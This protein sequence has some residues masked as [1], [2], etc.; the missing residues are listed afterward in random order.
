MERRPARPSAFDTLCT[1]RPGA[2]LLRQC[3]GGARGKLRGLGRAWA[4]GRLNND[5]AAEDELAAEARAFGIDPQTLPDQSTAVWPDAAPALDAFLAVA[6][7]W[8]VTPSGRVIGLDYAAVRAGL[9]LAG[10]EL[11][12]EVWSDVQ[13]IEQG[14]LVGLNG[15]K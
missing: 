15:E 13:H 14:A 1:G 4:A 12:P 7:Q 5:P 11:T 9:E 6:G 2:R 10:I 3:D 8:R